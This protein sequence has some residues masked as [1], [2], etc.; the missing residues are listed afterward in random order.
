MTKSQDPKLNDV[1]LGIWDLGFG[2]WALTAAL[3]VL[4]PA[5]HAQSASL[6]ISAAKSNNLAAVQAALKQ[7]ADV[8]A[9]E[10]DGTTALHWAARADNFEMVRVLV[11]AGADAKK[12]NRYGITALQLAAVNGSASM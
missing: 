3:L 6:L 5:I 12:A 4:G 11:R 10:A 7:R 8:N 1:R 2:F 9:A